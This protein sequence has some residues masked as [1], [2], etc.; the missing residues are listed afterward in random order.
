MM[1]PTANLQL[2]RPQLDDAA[3]VARAQAGERAAFESI[4]QMNNRRLYRVARGVLGGD[5]EADDV[6]QEAYLRAFMHLDEFRGQASLST[7]LTRIT[8][9]EALG[10]VRRRRRLAELSQVTATDG[11]ARILMFPSASSSDNPEGEAARAQVRR[12]LETA[13]DDLPDAFRLVFIMRDVE[14]MSIHETAAHLGIRPETVKTRLHRARKLLRAALHE[15][16]AS[17]LVE[18]F[19][20]AGD[21]CANMAE[22]V[23]ARLT[24]L[25]AQTDPGSQS[26]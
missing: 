17:T 13:I 24:T 22:R 9:N 7:W 20:F 15:K 16:L 2:S 5:V 10:R 11:E 3:L 23:L 8:V 25:R 14:E 6:V 21:R 12:L 19:P 4:V 26:K 1:A 18:V